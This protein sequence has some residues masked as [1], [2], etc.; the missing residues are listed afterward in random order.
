MTRDRIGLAVVAVLL[1]LV[2]VGTAAAGSARQ[3]TPWSLL[4]H[5]GSATRYLSSLGLDPGEFVVQRGHHNYAGPHCPGKGWTCTKATRVLQIAKAGGGNSFVC[6]AQGGGT[7]T[8]ASDDSSQTCT[9]VQVS[10]SS[11][12]TATCTEQA[13]T[14]TS[15]AYTQTCSINQTSGSGANKATVTQSLVQGSSTCSPPSGTSTLQSQGAAQTTTLIQSSSSGNTTASVSQ[16]AS[17]CAS[18]TT[19]GAAGQDQATSQQFTIRQGPPGFDPA[20]PNCPQNSGSI[21]ATATQSQHQR[22]YATAATSGTQSQRADLIGHIDQCS[23]SHADYSA[24]QTE[25]QFLAPNPA[26]TQK[27]VGPTSFKGKPA[28][29]HGKRVLLRGSCCSFQGT[30]G[31]DT[32]T[33]TQTTNQS[34]NPT[35]LQT[36]QLTTTAGTSGTC[37]GNISATQ[38]GVTNSTS[39]SGTTVNKSLNCQQQTCSDTQAPTALAWS[40]DTSGAYHDA[41]NLVATLTRTDTNAPVSG[42]TVSL[43]VGAESCAAVTNANGVASCSVTLADTPGAYS[44]SA[45]FA[46]TAFFL[47]SSTGSVSFTVTKAPTSLSYTGDVSGTYHD[48]ATLSGRLV[49]AH[50]TGTGVSGRTITFTAGSQS[51]TGVTDA[52]GAASCQVVLA[53]VPGGTYTVGASFDGSGDTYYTSSSST[54][55]SFTLNKAPTTLTYTGASNQDWND[56]VT[57]SAHLSEVH[58]P[59]T[60]VAGETVVFTLGTQGCSATT[61]ANGDASCQFVLTLTPGAYTVGVSFDGSGDTYFTSSSDSKPF[62]V[63]REESISTYTGATAGDYSDRVTLKGVLT[64]D[65]GSPLGG[66]QLTLKLGTQSCTGTTGSTGLAS[67]SL[68]ISQPAGTYQATASFGGDT[69]YAT[70]SGSKT[71]TVTPEED[72]LS[73]TGATSGKRGSAVSL[74]A[75][76]KTD[77][78]DAIAGRTV[79]FTI[80]TQSCTGTTNSSGAASCSLTLTQ[81]VGSYT[82]R[83]SFAGDGF[84]DPDSASTGFSI[85]SS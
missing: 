41:V 54:S 8:P 47:G 43:G 37:A 69:F 1:G 24:T 2:L 42:Q 51:C 40:G 9:I 55:Q 49:E 28:A 38:N 30:N 25:D 68:R 84:Y 66:R 67:C 52:T 36:E 79:S 75:S 71:F 46:G 16:T 18:S 80:G 20:N 70:S 39:Q 65:A 15:G 77:D 56:S 3:A 57:L 72:N 59:L 62:T 64:D 48:A 13:S 17:Q 34:A 44:A 82:V 19:T 23:T 31:S 78:G 11:S 5:G 60:P 58:N 14:T 26:V 32:C 50:N 22:G 81:S 63:N 53:Q 10:S 35:A 76:L 27:Q 7:A 4:S 29:P 33:I 73:Y 21:G 61:N 85:K 45:S 83:A 6:N 74:S 12:N